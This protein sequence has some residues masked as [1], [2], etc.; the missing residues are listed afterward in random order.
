MPRWKRSDET[1]VV[2]SGTR[3]D[4]QAPG[5]MAGTLAHCD[6]LFSLIRVCLVFETV[7][8]GDILK[9]ESQYN[10]FDG[11]VVIYIYNIS[12]WYFNV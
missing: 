4:V 1:S 7:Q 6:T 12:R 3:Q 11:S 9:A 2:A 5:T 10:Y 8:E